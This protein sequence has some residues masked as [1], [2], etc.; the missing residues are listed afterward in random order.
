MR[1][2]TGLV[3]AAVLLAGP[4]FAAD[5]V[6]KPAYKEPV[7]SWTGLYLGGYAGYALG[8]ADTTGTLD[9]SSPFGNDAPAA[10]PAY[11]A[12]MSPRLKPGGFTGG[13]MVGAN[14]QTGAIVWGVEGDFGA[15]NLSGSAPT[16]VT[17]PGHVNLTSSTAVSADWL[18]TV[19]GRVGGAVDRSLL[20][21]TAGAAFTNLGFRQANTY[22]TLGP[23]GVETFS[24]SN[25][26]VGLAGG[27]GWEY[28]FAPNWSGKIEYLHLAF[29]TLIGAGFIPTQPV[30]VTHSTT[31]TAD[32]VRAGVNYRFAP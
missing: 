13:G 31:F 24:M 15:F 26:R 19:R 2:V 8:S 17:P 29:G 23:A 14:W 21:A 5:P 4:A 6:T 27:A 11:N 3:G 16:S 22:A 10:Q 18:G 9:P 20:Y 1:K 12:N 30:S 25:A 7:F 32:V 28:M